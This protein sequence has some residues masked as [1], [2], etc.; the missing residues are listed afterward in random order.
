MIGGEAI[1]Q[2]NIILFNV[3]FI[4]FINTI[5]ER[6]EKIYK[7]CLWQGETA[8][9]SYLHLLHVASFSSMLSPTYTLE[10]LSLCLLLSY[11]KKH[12][13]SSFSKCISQQSATE[14]VHW[15]LLLEFHLQVL[16]SWIV[17]LFPLLLQLLFPTSLLS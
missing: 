3:Y 16:K 6:I 1:A 12:L 4:Y 14:K 11:Y 15:L 5:K 8:I 9:T 17:S 10:P 7:L 2:L 13:T